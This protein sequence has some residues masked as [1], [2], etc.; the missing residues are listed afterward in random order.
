MARV[1]K[2]RGTAANCVFKETNVRPDTWNI[3]DNCSGDC[4]TRAIV[5]AL[6]GAMT[7]DEV[8]AEQY[9]LAKEMH[10]VRNRTG[11]YDKILVTRGWRWIQLGKCMTR[12]E[13]AVRLKFYMPDACALTLSRSHIATVKNGELIDTWDS[14]AGRVFAILVPYEKQNAAIEAM[15]GYEPS[16]VGMNNIP[17]LV[18]SCHRRRRVFG[19]W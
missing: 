3:K 7:Y 19:Y 17:R 13:V 11:V 2:I 4:T 6:D 1:K 12:G 15:V 10:S 14:R 9:R 8:E 18:R 5:A 16:K